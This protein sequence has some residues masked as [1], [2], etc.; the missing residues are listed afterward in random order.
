MHTYPHTI[1]NGQGEKLTFLRQVQDGNTDYLEVENFV[2]PG[3]A[4]HAHALPAGRK[5]YGGEGDTVS[6][7][8]GTP[9][10][11]W[12]AGQEPLVCKGWIKPA[13]NIEHFLTEVYKSTAE[14]GGRPAPFDAAISDE[15]V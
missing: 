14:N 7:S 11:F 8:A 5:P 6:F 1:E 3:S 15:Q 12:N 4:P 13:D 10:R 2:R 9:H